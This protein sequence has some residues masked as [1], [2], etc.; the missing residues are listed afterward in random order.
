MKKTLFSF[1]L[2]ILNLSPVFSQEEF[3]NRYAMKLKKESDGSFSLINRESYSKILDLSSINDLLVPYN[4]KSAKVSGKDYEGIVSKEF[5]YK[6]YPGYDLKLVVDFAP[7]KTRVVPFMIYIHGGGWARGD[8]NSNRDLSQYCASKGGVTGVR[9]SYTL[10]DKPG[11]NILVTIEDV[12]DAVKWV[13]ANCK[14]LN[15]DPDNFGFMGGSAGGH[16]SAVAALSI[17]DT[18]VLV[19]VSGIYNLQSAKISAKATDGQRLKYFNNKDPE[20]LRVASP[21]NLINKKTIPACYLIHGTGDITVEYEQTVEFAEKLKGAGAKVLD[22]EI[23]PNYDH[24]VSSTKSDLKEDLFLK[25]FNFI[26]SN[27]NQ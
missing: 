7:E 2:I 12:K 27:L 23:I 19:G 4:H 6:S 3:T 26:T 11:A 14:E 21:V 20:T 13:Q 17:P 16:L 24:N 1:L 8:F 22:I 9:I 18:K 5:V 10:A 15:V 25:M